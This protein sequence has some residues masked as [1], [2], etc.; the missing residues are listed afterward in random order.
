MATQ[1][2]LDAQAVQKIL[3][4]QVESRFHAHLGF[5]A[6]ATLISSLAL[7]VLFNPS[8][9]FVLL[10]STIVFC[11]CFSAQE[12]SVLPA[13]E[14]TLNVINALATSDFQNYAAKSNS[15]NVNRIHV[16][17]NAFQHI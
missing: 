13:N 6:V 5:S 2:Q 10:A 14:H 7:K 11:F 4:S 8:M 15:L 3:Q 1:V 17:Y 12:I 9:P 16:A